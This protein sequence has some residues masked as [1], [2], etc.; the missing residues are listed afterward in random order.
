MAGSIGTPQLLILSG[1]GDA[2]ELAALN[3]TVFANI[4]DVGKNLQDHPWVPL[5]WAVNDVSLDELQR[6]PTLLQELF[7]EYNM[8][9]GGAIANNP[10]GNH[11]GWLRLADDSPFFVN[12]P[13]PASG[14]LSPHFEFDFEVCF[15]STL[16]PH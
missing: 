3:I 10:G 9:R 14:P 8:T 5:Q 1:I 13:D 11:L 2:Q 15:A 6:Q 16:R 4:P 12:N 7:A